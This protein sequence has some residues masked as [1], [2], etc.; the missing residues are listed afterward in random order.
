[1]KLSMLIFIAFVS[2]S[3]ENLARGVCSFPY[4]YVI[5][6]AVPSVVHTRCSSFAYSPDSL[7]SFAAASQSVPEDKTVKN[8]TTA[9]TR[10]KLRP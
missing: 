3:N 5:P 7:S 1:M 10:T 9:N 8:V 4:R 2:I 6:S